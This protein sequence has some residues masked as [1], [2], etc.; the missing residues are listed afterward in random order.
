MRAVFI[1]LVIALAAGCA[2]DANI[3]P[4]NALKPPADDADDATRSLGAT[5]RVYWSQP[6]SYDVYS[7]LGLFVGGANCAID[8]CPA[9][10]SP[11][12]PIGNLAVY[13]YMETNP[14]TP[15]PAVDAAT[16]AT[17]TGVSSAGYGINSAWG[18]VGINADGSGSIGLVLSPKALDQSGKGSVIT[19][20]PQVQLA[21]PANPWV[22]GDTLQL[23]VNISHPFTSVPFHDGSISSDGTTYFY[24]C[25]WMTGPGTSS[26]VWCSNFFQ[27]KLAQ[28]A[29]AQLYPASSGLPD[30]TE[31]YNGGALL[32]SLL[33]SSAFTTSCG[34][35][36]FTT[37]NAG[38]ET[39]CFQITR[40]QFANAI[41]FINSHLGL[42]YSADPSQWKIVTFALDIESVATGSNNPQIGLSWNGFSLS[43]MTTGAADPGTAT[44]PLYGFFNSAVTRHLTQ[45]SPGGAPSGFTSE[46]PL[47]SA[48][49]TAGAGGRHGIYS[50]VVPGAPNYFT[51]R[52]P[53][54][55]GQ[56]SYQG[57]LGYLADGGG[58]AV[59]RCALGG[60][61]HIDVTSTCP[62]GY[63][64]EETLG[65]TPETSTSPPPPPPPPPPPSS[66]W[67]PV[68]ALAGA[69]NPVSHGQITGWA[70]DIGSSVSGWVD[71]YLDGPYGTG[72]YVGRYDANGAAG[73]AVS[74]ACLTSATNYLFVIPTA[75]LPSGSK[76][77]LYAIWPD[78]TPVLLTGGDGTYTI[79]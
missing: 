28:G 8:A 39:Y 37:S 36:A 6:T 64:L 47:F 7:Q 2:G 17:Y 13:W 33:G 40:T 18:P 12:D 68:G 9:V 59:S 57:L 63:Q 75:G 24:D 58:T 44:H 21:T 76:I 73:P 34:N 74:D 26:V 78:I 16:M 62:P 56:A 11:S 3:T 52:D 77:Y 1:T 32:N 45:S 54:C 29:E 31:A 41:G 14:F 30:E 70:C 15:S 60:V 69:V 71:L 4:R 53:G 42:G 49:D 72:T 10:K 66:P 67:G 43:A 25:F 48:F 5:T 19:V 55:E 38:P 79:P 22:D 27:D 20:V 35:G 51:S 46:G 65:Y 23:T 50:C 61:D